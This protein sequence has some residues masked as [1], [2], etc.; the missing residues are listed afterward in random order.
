MDQRAPLL[1]GYPEVVPAE[2]ASVHLA[3]LRRRWWLVVLTALIAL[4]AGL[5]V[6]SRQQKRY[7][8]TAT[9]LLTNSEPIN[10]LLHSAPG[11]SADPERDLNT[12]VG[13]VKLGSNARAVRTGLGLRMPLDELLREVRATADGNSNLLS[14][15]VRDPLPARSAAVANAFARA[16][17]AFRRQAAQGAY[18]SAAA[19]AVAQLRSLSPV[20][21]RGA[22]GMALRRQLRQLQVTGA[23]QTG[24]ARFVDAASAPTV[25]ATP[26]PKVTGVAALLLGALVGV[27]GAILLGGAAVRE[28]PEEQPNRLE[29][30]AEPV[31]QG[32]GKANVAT[33]P[34]ANISRTQAR[35]AIDE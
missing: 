22:Q 6:A 1:G 27:I 4:A 18:K 28:R 25:A 20:Q 15:T 7:D 24:G 9:V 35:T 17:V 29:A 10:L 16:Y 3:A 26:R 23:L 11:S 34:P 14:I 31:H 32:N 21:R 12:Q 13:L 5:F 8:A 30:A 33:L 19:Q 2:R